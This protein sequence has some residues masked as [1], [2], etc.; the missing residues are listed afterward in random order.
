MKSKYKPVGKLQSQNNQTWFHYDPAVNASLIHH[1]LTKDISTDV[2]SNEEE[3]STG[4]Q[5]AS[6]QVAGLAGATAVPRGHL[7][8]VEG[9]SEALSPLPAT[10]ATSAIH[11]WTFFP[12]LLPTVLLLLTETLVPFRKAFRGSKLSGFGEVFFAC[13]SYQLSSH[14]IAK[15]WKVSEMKTVIAL[16]TLWNLDMSVVL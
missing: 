10:L 11:L 8:P 2:L 14:T 9:S 1:I 7:Q 5:Q 4:A 12:P 3:N 16:I 6:G 15:V 13:M